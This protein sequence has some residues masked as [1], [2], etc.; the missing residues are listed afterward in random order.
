MDTLQIRP[1][2]WAK[3]ADIDEVT[4]FSKED[5]KC[6]RELRAVLRKYK[7]VDRF[8]ITL[9][10]KH[11]EIAED[12]AMVEY[13]D[14]ESRMLIIKPVKCAEI[15]ENQITVTN[16]QLAEGDVVAK[17]VCVCARTNQGHTGGHTAA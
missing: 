3:I 9:V 14:H 8:G 5:E 11:F 13:T 4:P 7:A 2:Q 15:D 6:F 16:W 1:M 17:R 12:E 10:H